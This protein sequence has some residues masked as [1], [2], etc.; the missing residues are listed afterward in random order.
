MPDLSYY[1]NLEL[2]DLHDNYIDVSFNFL[3]VFPPYGY[4]TIHHHNEIIK[5]PIIPI[6]H[7]DGHI[8]NNIT[9]T[10]YQYHQYHQ[11]QNHGRN[12]QKTKTVYDDA[13]NVHNNSVQNSV[14]KSLEYILKYECRLTLRECLDDFSAYLRGIKRWYHFFWKSTVRVHDVVEWCALRDLHSV[15]GVTYGKLFQHVYNIIKN[16]ESCSELQNILKQELDASIGY[17]TTGK[18]NRLV[19]VLCGFVEEINVGISEAE[20]MQ[21]QIA[22]IVKNCGDDREEALKQVQEILT[23]FNISKKESQAWLDA[24]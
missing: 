14:N 11:Y 3:S 6:I 22:M 19:N 9:Y 15:H 13:Q 1:I 12:Q 18:F 2:L 8:F 20:Q 16:H 21:N 10:P 17:C 4:R 23:S 24:I 7:I 5:T